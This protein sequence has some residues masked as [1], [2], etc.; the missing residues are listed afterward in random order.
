MPRS[1]FGVQ[2]ATSMQRSAPLDKEWGY[3]VACEKFGKALI[4]SF[5]TYTRGPRKGKLKG[6]LVWRQVT[7]GGWS[8]ELGGV[9]RPG[10]DDWRVQFG[11]PDGDQHGATVV[12]RWEFRAKD[13]PGLVTN[14]RTVEEAHEQ[15]KRM[16]RGMSRF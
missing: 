13:Q 8:R 14:V 6:F 10:T 3:N 16:Q 5:P 15:A 7:E 1:K 4:D 9:L 12:A 11:Y 2:Y